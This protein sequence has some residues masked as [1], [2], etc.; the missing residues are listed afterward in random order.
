ML[1]P[2]IFLG[3]RDAVNY[4]HRDFEATDWKPCECWKLF[5]SH[6]AFQPPAGEEET[7]SD[8]NDND[9]DASEGAVGAAEASDTAESE[10][11]AETPLPSRNLFNNNPG[12]ASTNT[13]RGGGSFPQQRH[14]RGSAAGRT[15]TKKNSANEEC[16]KRKQESLE[17]M[18]EV[19]KKR[20]AD[21]NVCMR[22]TARAQAFEMARSL[23]Q[24]HAAAGNAEKAAEYLQKMEDLLTPRDECDSN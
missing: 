16:K 19:Q 3:K 18:L 5:K 11:Q 20:Q 12:T 21:F 17:G 15:S 24:Q 6:R 22:N 10:T 13:A 2:G 8:D 9:T 4:R 1:L 14:S 7:K 23:Q